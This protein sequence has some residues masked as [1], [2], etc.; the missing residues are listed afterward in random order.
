MKLELMQEF[1]G[2]L[3]VL[4]SEHEDEELYDTMLEMVKAYVPITLT[5]TPSTEFSLSAEE[6][7]SSLKFLEEHSCRKAV[8]YRQLVYGK[9]V[10]NPI[11]VVRIVKCKDC[12][13]E[14]DC[15]DYGTW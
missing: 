13:T 10:D 15:T 6:V 12:N 9:L 2:H 1:V 11:G 5:Y 4:T 7:R 3:H 14:H 8:Q